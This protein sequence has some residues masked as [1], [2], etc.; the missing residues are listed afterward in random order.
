MNVNDI[1]I[2]FTYHNP[3]N[4][5]L[6]RFDEIRGLAKSLGKSILIH[7][8]KKEDVQRSIEKLRECIFFAIASIVVPELSQEVKE[9]K[10]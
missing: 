5:D 7:G 1:D 8:G 9:N 3:C 4:V 10:I 2:L 6:I